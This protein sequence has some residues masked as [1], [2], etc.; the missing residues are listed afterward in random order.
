MVLVEC[1]G[2]AFRLEPSPPL[3]RRRSRRPRDWDLA[4]RTTPS[5]EDRIVANRKLR[6]GG[7]NE[8]MGQA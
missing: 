2:L 4:D 3:R 1:R 8:G 5:D 6:V 7:T